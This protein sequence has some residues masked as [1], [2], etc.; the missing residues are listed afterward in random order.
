ML[1]LF[2]SNALRS[3]LCESYNVIVDVPKARYDLVNP[4]KTSHSKDN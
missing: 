2:L 4:G 3:N 1:S